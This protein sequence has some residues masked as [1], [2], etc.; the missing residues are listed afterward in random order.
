M[1][2]LITHLLLKLETNLKKNKN[3]LGLTFY[4]LWDMK[5]LP[6][7]PES[8]GIFSLAPVSQ[9]DCVT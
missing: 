6:R 5:S 9:N 8:F 3:K 7:C 2:F 1:L 4:P